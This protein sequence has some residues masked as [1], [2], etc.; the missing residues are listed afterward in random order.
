MFWISNFTLTGVSPNNSNLGISSLSDVR[1][2]DALIRTH[3]ILAELV[4][5]DGDKHKDV[6]VQAYGY[7]MQ[8]W[9]VETIVFYLLLL[10]RCYRHYCSLYSGHLH[11]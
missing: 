4:S 2:L 1:Q 11:M 8:L 10:Q 7:V 9:K 6:V 5:L 3:V